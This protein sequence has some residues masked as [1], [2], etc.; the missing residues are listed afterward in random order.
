MLGIHTIESAEVGKLYEIRWD[1]DRTWSRDP[2]VNYSF[3]VYDSHFLKITPTRIRDIT[4]GTPCIVV[5]QAK[6]R[7]FVLVGEDIISLDYA[8]QGFELFP[9]TE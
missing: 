4:S 6:K 7:A 5:R 3:H 2:I 9:I 8:E 1:N